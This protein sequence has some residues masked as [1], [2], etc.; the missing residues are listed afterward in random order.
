MDL[1]DPR[2]RA[3]LSTERVT[4][5]PG[6]LTPLA[7]WIYHGKQ[8]AW[9][10]GPTLKEILRFPEQDTH[11]EMLNGAGDSPLHAL[12]HKSRL[13]LMQIILGHKPLL[14]YRE[15]ATGRTP[16]EIAEDNCTKLIFS[17]PPSVLVATHY[18]LQKTTIHQGP[19]SF[20]REGDGKGK[21]KK[22]AAECFAALALCKEVMEKYPGK[23]QLVSLHEA[24]EVAKR[25]A[26]Q[27]V[28]VS[29]LRWNDPADK[30]EGDEVE[31]WFKSAAVSGEERL[32]S[33]RGSEK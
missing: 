18:S 31:E 25:L 33:E 16:I 30:H 17:D 28:K 9:E 11:L 23:R 22:A 13:T 4:E 26:A 1:I 12:T 15:N 27:Q 6:A 21:R 10:Q 14:V 3:S 7:Q 24:N 19:E 20:L 5:G 32:E 2:L 8:D 29:R